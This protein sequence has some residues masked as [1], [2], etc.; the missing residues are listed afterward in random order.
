MTSSIR[1]P[2]TITVNRI[3]TSQAI[4]GARGLKSA[5]TP[6]ATV[7]RAF[8]SLRGS[9][10]VTANGRRRNLTNGTAQF[11]FGADVLFGDK[12]TFL[13]TTYE[14]TGTPVDTGGR[15]QFVVA[16]IREFAGDG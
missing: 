6:V 8:V 15:Q 10:N 3:T 7:V 9:T 4:T 16:P 2:H 14:V 5:A 13:G 11:D 1:L 12:F